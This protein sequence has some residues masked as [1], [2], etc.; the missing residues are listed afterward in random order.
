MKRAAES[1]AVFLREL[2]A[3]IRSAALTSIIMGLIIC[4]ASSFLILTAGKTATSQEKILSQ[5]NS[6]TMRTLTILGEKASGFDTG[7]IGALDQYSVIESVIGMGPIH[8]YV[9]AVNPASPKV[10]GRTLYTTSAYALHVPAAPKNFPT[11]AISS[12]KALA[13]IGVSTRS[14]TVREEKTGEEINVIDTKELPEVLKIYEPIILIPRNI[15]EKQPLS[16]ISV[17]AR[18]L[19]DIGSVEKILQQHLAGIPRSQ[20]KI[21]LPDNISP[22]KKAITGELIASNRGILL[23]TFIACVTATHII[24]WTVVL[25]RRKDYGRRRALGASR[26]LI[27]TLTVMHA[28]FIAMLSA[29]SGVLLTQLWLWFTHNSLPPLSFLGATITALTFMSTLGAFVPATWA[30]HRDPLMELRTP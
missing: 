5:L 22:L 29:S 19:E 1:I 14:A 13:T 15:E 23:A 18:T 25:L 27:V 6:P 30:A 10:P 4:G 9:S 3:V 17:T 26:S 16:M 24:V 2:C 12:P 8:D 7:L 28:C 11:S 20:V 21:Q